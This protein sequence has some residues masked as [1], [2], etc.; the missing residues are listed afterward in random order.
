M[1]K[2][3]AHDAS[4]VA[5]AAAAV[6]SPAVVDGVPVADGIGVASTGGSGLVAGPGVG[7]GVGAGLGNAVVDGIIDVDEAAGNGVGSG[8]GDGVGIIVTDCTS[9]KKATKNRFLPSR[10]CSSRKSKIDPTQTCTFPARHCKWSYQRCQNRCRGGAHQKRDSIT[11]LC[12]SINQAILEK[13]TNSY[14]LSGCDTHCRLSSACDTVQVTLLGC[15]LYEQADSCSL[16]R[17]AHEP[18]NKGP[19]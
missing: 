5:H 6:V 12:R 8:V 10:N 17:L 15:V 4:N 7:S 1:S 19:E 11:W 9:T 16:I 14:W 2:H 18:E 3:W 13:N